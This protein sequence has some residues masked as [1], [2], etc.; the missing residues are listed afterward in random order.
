MT[1][2]CGLFTSKFMVH[3]T[4]CDQQFHCLYTFY[5]HIF[6]SVITNF[7]VRH[8]VLTLNFDLLI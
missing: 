7:I 1:L 5:V 4:V 3:G 2:I 6:F 8:Y